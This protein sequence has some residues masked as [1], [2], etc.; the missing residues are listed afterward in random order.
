MQCHGEYG[1]LAGWVAPVAR[2]LAQKLVEVPGGGSDVDVISSFYAQSCAPSNNDNKLC[3]ACSGSGPEADYSD[4]APDGE[5]TMADR[6]AGPLG[7]LRCLEEDAADIGFVDH[8]TAWGSG[9]YAEEKY[10]NATL[11]NESQFR[12]VCN[13]GCRPL[14]DATLVRPPRC[15]AAR[16]ASARPCQLSVHACGR[17]SA[18][19]DGRTGR[20]ARCG[21]VQEGCCVLSQTRGARCRRTATWPRCRRIR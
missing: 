18:L 19:C 2:I 15:P 6:Y 13:G 12:A 1:D 7:V 3:D 16:P 17:P 11:R 9:Q 5:C 8:W 14:A 10:G 4:A 21:A 20:S